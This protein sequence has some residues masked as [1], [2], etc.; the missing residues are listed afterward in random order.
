LHDDHATIDDNE[1]I[2][3]DV[4]HEAFAGQLTMMTREHGMCCLAGLAEQIRSTALPS[5]SYYD[6]TLANI[7]KMGHIWNK[8]NSDRCR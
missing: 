3:T 6:Q 8:H 2:D 4:I 1:T 5:A 7:G